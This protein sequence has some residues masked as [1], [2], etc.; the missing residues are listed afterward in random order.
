MVD[1]GREL[2]HLSN[3]TV[4]PPFAIVTNI[5]A[6][7]RA[8]VFAHLPRDE[9][10][11][12][13]CSRNEPNRDWNLPTM[14]HSHEFLKERIHHNKDG[15]NFRHNNLDVWPAL[16]RLQPK[17][18]VTTGF[19]PTHLYAFLWAKLHR[20]THVCM[21]DGTVESESSLSW[22]HKLARRLVFAGSDAFVAASQKGV[23]L[24][25][26]YGVP[27]ARIFQSHLCADNLLFA[28][29]AANTDR[30]FD[31][32]FSGQLQEHK[33][34]FLFVDVCVE[35]LRRRGRCKALVLGSGP[36]RDEVMRR[37]LALGV[38]VTYPGFVQQAELPGWYSR[39][40]VLLFTTRMDAWGVVANEAMAA[41][42]PVICTPHA[43]VAGELVVDGETGFVR[44]AE[45]GVWADAVVHLL[46]DATL[47]ERMSRAGRIL[48]EKYNYQVAANGIEAACLRARQ[49]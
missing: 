29:C 4:Q 22:F 1:N 18:V 47:W 31:V 46:E 13:Y 39:A 37:L 19:N 6:P 33:L 10:H 21:T 11:V 15:F 24:Y 38:D 16:K 40:R 48:V 28:E 49:D 25:R 5:P 35:V 41:G 12:I 42:T 30:P 43:G 8:A 9:F 32:M 17:V 36:L 3:N 14:S 27:S 23:A 44:P 45:T 26:S 20:I 2:G 34:P 7:Y